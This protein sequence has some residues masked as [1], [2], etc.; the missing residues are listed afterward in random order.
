MALLRSALRSKPWEWPEIPPKARTSVRFIDSH[1]H[2]SEY[3]EPEG[4]LAYALHTDTTLLSSGVDKDSSQT[5][6]MVARETLGS[7]RAFVGTH[8]S[9]AE[10]EPDLSWFGPSLSQ[11]AGTGE[12]GL[13]PKYSSIEPG[14]TQSRVFETQLTHA[15][16][17]QKPIQVHSRGAEKRCLEVLSGFRLGSVLM[18]WFQ[19]AEL[20]KEV[21]ERG[22][23][24]SFGPALLY[25]KKLQSMAVSV[26]R[27]LVLTETDAPVPF[28]PLGGARGS[29]LIPSVV[30][31]LAGLWRASFEEAR[32]AVC[33][34]GRRYLGEPE[35]G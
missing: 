33:E 34:N 28:A 7:V 15:E 3:E 32:V 18:H 16:N 25:S 27:S 12:I 17:A 23:F 30:F 4:L 35:K 20:I 11:A 29:S 19:S 24:V 9:E 6:L 14:S 10:K 21:S 31:A 8:P 2:I 1:L 22:Y 26:D 13:D 5:T